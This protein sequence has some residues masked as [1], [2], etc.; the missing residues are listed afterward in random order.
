MPARRT[1]A[2]SRTFTFTFKTG[3][4][5]GR[6][7]SVSIVVP[8]LVFFLDG[9]LRPRYAVIVLVAL[10][11]G[12]AAFLFF[13]PPTRILVSS[14]CPKEFLLPFSVQTIPPCPKRLPAFSNFCQRVPEAAIRAFSFRFAVSR[15]AALAAPPH[16][17]NYRDRRNRERH[18]VRGNAPIGN[19]SAV[20]A[21]ASRTVCRE[22]LHPGALGHH[23]GAVPV[24]IRKRLL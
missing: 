10:A 6:R 12:S 7:R 2:S 13:L 20:S 23:V 11:A 17:L 9:L 15:F 8:T 1:Q 18:A 21:S 3:A 14:V 19:L 5:A 22:T 16:T 4:S 24:Y